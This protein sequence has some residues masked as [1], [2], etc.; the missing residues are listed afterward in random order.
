[1]EYFFAF[2]WD[3]GFLGEAG[4]FAMKSFEVD[5]KCF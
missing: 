5:Q 3:D 1:M 2:C 4:Y